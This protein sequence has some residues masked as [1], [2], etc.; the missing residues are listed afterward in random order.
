MAFCV[1]SVAYT[2]FVSWFV[3]RRSSDGLLRDALFHVIA[4]LLLHASAKFIAAEAPG[5]LEKALF[6]AAAAGA[7]AWGYRRAIL[8]TS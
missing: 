8:K 3:G 5:N 1:T 6:Y 7:S 2:L 4:M